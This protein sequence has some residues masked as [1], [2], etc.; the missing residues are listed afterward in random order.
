[1]L[2]THHKAL[3]AHGVRA[4]RPDVASLVGCAPVITKSKIARARPKFSNG[5]K[6]AQTA[7]GGLAPCGALVSD[8]ARRCR[9][10]PM[11]EISRGAYAPREPRLPA[12]RF[13]SCSTARTAALP[14]CRAAKV[15]TVIPTTPGRS[16]WLE[17]SAVGRNWAGR[18]STHLPSPIWAMTGHSPGSS[19]HAGTRPTAYLI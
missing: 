12:E 17:G 3:C 11:L 2:H 5:W 19:R 1:M 14:T 13:Q 15:R 6:S 16:E 18:C 8:A 7:R 10:W 4:Q 9:L